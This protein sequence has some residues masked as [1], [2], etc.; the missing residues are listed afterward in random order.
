MS[1]RF[2]AA[3]LDDLHWQTGVPTPAF[4]ELFESVGL[5]RDDDEMTFGWEEHLA[6][7]LELLESYSDGRQRG[8]DAWRPFLSEWPSSTSS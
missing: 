5:D 6:F 7:R 2:R 4:R 1:Y 3:R 8:S